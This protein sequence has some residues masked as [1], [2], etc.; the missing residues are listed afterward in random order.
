ML[1]QVKEFL[2]NELKEINKSIENEFKKTIFLKIYLIKT[3]KVLKR[4]LLY[5]KKHLFK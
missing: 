2:E 4:I 3:T 1:D 5:L